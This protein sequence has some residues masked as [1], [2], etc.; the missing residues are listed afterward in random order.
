VS[1]IVPVYKGG[2][3]LPRLLDALFAQ[4]YP[5]SRYE[6]IVVDNGSTD[7]TPRILAAPRRRGLVRV[8]EGAPGSYAAR[9][10]GV[11]RAAGTILAFTDADCLP[12]PDWLTQ[13]TLALEKQSLDVVAGRVRQ[14]RPPRE[15]LIQTIDRLFFLRQ[16]WYVTQG[17]GATANL[18]CKSAVMERV[19]GFDRRLLSSGDRLFCQQ[20]QKAGFRMGYGHEAVV[21][22]EIRATL[23]GLARKEFRLGL[24]FGQLVGLH[25]K[26]QGVSLFAQTYLPVPGLRA[27]LR[28]S[29][30]ELGWPRL[31]LAMLVYSAIRLPCRT[32][33]FF[34]G[35]GYKGKRPFR[36]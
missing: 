9:N 13:G 30:D 28:D 23:S 24:G 26:G 31:A 10:A 20:A 7:D 14:A 21:D 5:P 35:I 17:F 32:L 34:R 29:R 22:H 4:D 6:V 3:T 8:Y 25:Q 19:G 27:C 12:A 36:G 33:G 2:R 16:S 11:A 18:L 1:V 15:N